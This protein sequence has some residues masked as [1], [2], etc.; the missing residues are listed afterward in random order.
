MLV[1]GIDVGGPA[2]GF[3]AVAL[4][5]GR[6]RAQL[7]TGDI[8]HLVHWAVHPPSGLHNSAPRSSA[9]GTLRHH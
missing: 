1:I 6:Y 9:S 5:G 8:A 3:H 4:E 7:A 2:K